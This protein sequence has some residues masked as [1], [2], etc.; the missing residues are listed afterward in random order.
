[1]RFEH[2]IHRDYEF[3]D[4][5]NIASERGGRRYCVRIPYAALGVLRAAIDSFEARVKG[6]S[7]T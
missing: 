2:V 3:G 7:H 1:L 4:V 6:D 5:L